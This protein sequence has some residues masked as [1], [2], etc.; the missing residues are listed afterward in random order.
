MLKVHLNFLAEVSERLKILTI[1]SP[2]TNWFLDGDFIG[3][4]EGNR[5]LV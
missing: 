5:T 2:S 4:G 3:A 1:K